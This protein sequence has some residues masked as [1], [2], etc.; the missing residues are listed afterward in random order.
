MNTAVASTA[1]P[2]DVVVTPASFGQR[3]QALPRSNQ[4]GLAVGLLLLVALLVYLS[5]GARSGDYRP[6]FTGLSDKDGGAIAAQLAQQQVPYRIDPGGTILVPAAQVYDVRMK[7]AAAGLPKGGLVGFELLD[8]PSLGQTQFNER[9]NFQ[10]ALE[11]ELTRTITALADVA[12][13][14]VH[15][16]MPQQ[17][18]FF[19]EQQK[20]SAS[21]MLHLRGG[22]MLDRAQVAGI[23]HLVSSSVPELQPRAVSV[24]DQTG[25]LLSGNDEQGAGLGLDAHQQQYKNQLESSLARRIEALLEPIVG[26]GNLRSTVT[27]DLDF[28]QTEQ[29]SE[30]YAPNQGASA[31]QAVRSQQTNESSN[32]AG[33]AQPTGV[34]GAISNQ[35][36]VPAQA[37]INGAS[38]PLQGTQQGLG[39]GANSRRDSVTNYEVDKTVRVTRA[40]TGE[41]RRLNAAVVLN[42]RS[43]TD[44]KGRTTTEPLAQEEVERVTQLVRQAIGFNQQRGDSLQVVSSAFV[45]PEVVETSLPLWQQTWAR[46]LF[47]MGAVPLALVLVALIIVFGMVRPAIKAAFPP[48]VII[49]EKVPQG[50]TLSEVVGDTPALPAPK[51]LGLPALE[52]PIDATKLERTRMFA[53]GN[54][55]AVANVVRAW[56]QGEEPTTG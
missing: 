47:A 32:G 51:A 19:R 22:R 13:A 49:D 30:A 39:G 42:H 4:M 16:A 24:L 56:M 54:P 43:K 5:T 11:G 15:L 45:K 8:K 2:V 35:P 40:A 48:A 18:G 29:T 23:V 27:A 28:S 37:P 46:D 12:D 53:Q 10:R 21:V 9:L 17:T 52:A 55:L 20:P 34:P 7:L 38:A 50:A 14:R 26:P 3:L 33:N 41:I 25:K 1:P 6:V 44:A 31:V 36:P